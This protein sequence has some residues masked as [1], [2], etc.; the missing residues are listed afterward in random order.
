MPRR[1]T[2][3]TNQNGPQTSSGSATVPLGE[4]KSRLDLLIRKTRDVFYKPMAVAE[5]L[6]RN[7]TERLNLALKDEY[8]RLSDRWSK[9]VARELWGSA[10][11]SNSRYWDQMFDEPLMTPETLLALGK[12]N[13]S[14]SF[15]GL[16]ETY[17]YAHL[18]DK[19][20][21]IR[22]IL[23]WVSGQKPTE[24]RLVDLI[25]KFVNDSRYVQSV[26]KLYEVVVYALFE[27]VI[28]RLD[29]KISL[30]INPNSL[31]LKTF[32][33]FAFM[34]LG[35]NASNPCIEQ[36]ARLYRVGKANASDGGLDMWAN[37]GPAVQVK[38]ISLTMDG[39]GDICEKIYAD[40]IIIVCKDAAAEVVSAVLTQVGLGERIRGVIAESLL[41]EW[42][43]KACNMAEDR[44]MGGDLLH[45]LVRE[46]GHEFSTSQDDA[47]DRMAE[48]TSRREYD[49]RKLPD[50]WNTLWAR[51]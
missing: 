37:F 12:A 43:H 13:K 51:A 31:I 29:A 19:L 3:L 4:A 44:D 27:V 35:V 49:Y 21:G 5:I 46:M 48:F 24:F 32:D 28:Q 16:V 23:D 45:V 20:Q 9:N 7:R 1:P 10:T 15:P 2:D 11:S 17:I 6:H 30:T 39:C 8:R 40:K 26:D 33:D 34:V 14:R 25:N 47:L 18:N 22:Q 41:C 42:Y 50:G 36:P 38:H